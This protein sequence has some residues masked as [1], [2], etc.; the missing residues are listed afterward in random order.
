MPDKRIIPTPKLGAIVT[1]RLAS[2]GNPTRTG[3]FIRAGRTTGRMNPGVWWEITDGRGRFW[4]LSPDAHHLLDPSWF[5]HLKVDRSTE[6]PL[7]PPE[8]SDA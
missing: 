3:Y 8:V 4:K 2:T 1:N 5:P 7:D 6:L